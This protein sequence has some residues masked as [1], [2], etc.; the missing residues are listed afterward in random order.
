MCPI[1][2]RAGWLPEYRV[3]DF[4]QTVRSP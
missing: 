2:K 4:A 1:A 3:S